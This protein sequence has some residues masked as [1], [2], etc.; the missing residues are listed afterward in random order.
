[1]CTP[2]Y[3]ARLASR[4]AMARLGSLIWQEFLSGFLE[5]KGVH[6]L[7]DT[8]RAAAAKRAKAVAADARAAALLAAGNEAGAEIAKELA[9]S[10]RK[11]AEE[12]RS[13]TAAEKKE[14]AQANHDFIREE[15]ERMREFCLAAS[16]QGTLR[17]KDARVDEYV[18]KPAKGGV[19]SLM[20]SDSEEDEA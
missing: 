18:E 20:S 12:L 14:R 19:V 17:W 16:R 7:T 1:M 2:Y 15:R 9:A 8:G 5:S 3:P 6:D 11:Q 10:L 4:V 13:P